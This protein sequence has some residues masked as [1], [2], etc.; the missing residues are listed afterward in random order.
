MIVVK[1]SSQ[2]VYF[3]KHLKPVEIRSSVAAGKRP[4]RAVYKGMDTKQVY[5]AG[6]S[7]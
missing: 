5:H 7:I 1:S 3:L 6:R 2:S 4:R